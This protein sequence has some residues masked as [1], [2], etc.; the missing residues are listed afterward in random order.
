MIAELK[1]IEVA[2]CRV[3]PSDEAKKLVDGIQKAITRAIAEGTKAQGQRLEERYQQYTRDL[4]RLTQLECDLEG[5]VKI[6]YQ[7][8]E[9]IRQSRLEELEVEYKKDREIASAIRLLANV[10]ACALSESE[11]YKD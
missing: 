7:E 9:R 6:Q 1:T 8:A 11:C 2:A 3:L 10:F 5:K 4:A